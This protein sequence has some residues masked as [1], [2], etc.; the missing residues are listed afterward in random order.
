MMNHPVLDLPGV[1]RFVESIAGNLRDGRSVIVRLP[2]NATTGIREA[3]KGAVADDDLLHW[4]KVNT[5]DGAPLPTLCQNIFPEALSDGI[6]L[7]EGLYDHEE[8]QAIVIELGLS[9]TGHWSDW[10]KFLAEFSEI[11]H[12]INDL[13]RSQ[14]AVFLE[15][16]DFSLLPM[17]S[18]SFRL[19]EQRWNDVIDGIDTQLYAHRAL[20]ER[21]S[22]TF[23]QRQL[24]AS[25]CCQLSKW[26]IHLCESLC[27]LD[28]E[29]MLNPLEHLK[30]YA[31]Q[32]GFE[33]MTDNASEEEKWAA[34]IEAV[35]DG[36]SQPH[37]AYLA[38]QGDE[39]TINQ[40]IWQ[41]EVTVLY[42]HAEML[43]RKI[44]ER[45]GRQIPIPFRT[46][47]RETIEKLYDIDIGDLYFY[48]N[49]AHVS[50]RPEL[51]SFLKDL[52]NTRNALAHFSTVDPHVITR[53]H[54]EKDPW[55][56]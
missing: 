19:V 50:C 24:A 28:I 42:P 30:A 8:F 20:R 45:E 35:F 55:E 47:N 53:R 3:V 7:I 32:L 46:K 4:T 49:Q 31:N 39:E 13:Y 29:K 44:L 18:K 17:P 41:A 48:F 54:L 9:E 16:P 1:R 15:G 14:F 56:G 38:L 12:G 25:I 27:G 34:G 11:N 2:L 40:R 33:K 51:S 22:L 21:A 43:R 37:S 10:S 23:L 52:R 5:D 26:D 6:P 36:E